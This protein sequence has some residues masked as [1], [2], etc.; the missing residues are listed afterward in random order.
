MLFHPD[1]DW[2]PA[3][4][5]AEPAQACSWCGEAFTVGDIVDGYTLRRGG[6]ALRLHRLCFE[7]L[8]LHEGLVFADA[9]AFLARWVPRAEVR[10]GP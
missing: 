1:L 7:H 9:D 6:E 4:L 2:G 3:A 8:T 5:D 10:Y